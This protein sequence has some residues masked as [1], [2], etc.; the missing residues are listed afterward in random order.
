MAKII[1]SD[2][3]EAYSLCPRKAFLLMAGATSDPGPHDYELFIR[4]QAEANRQVHR[5]RLAKVDEVVP[6]S[7]PADLAV[8]RDVL[9]NVELATGVLQARCDFLTKVDEPSRLGRHSYEPVKVIG[10]CKA[11]R[12]DTLG[13]AYQ[14]L[15]LSEVQGRQPP[16]G[17][18]IRLGGHPCKVKL[19]SKCKD[20][21]RIVDALR[22][23]ADD[24]A[25]DAPPV[26]LNKHCPSCPFRGACLQQAE[27]E[28]NLSLLDRMTP[29]L[30]RKYHDKGIFTVRQL[31]HIYTD[32]LQLRLGF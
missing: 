31:S 25:S 24:P 23:W 28:G 27:K 2:L 26:I 14:C 11:S 32:L 21:R 30:M 4:E 12:T 19:T 13:L 15:V 16:S 1:T 20:V 22:A 3:V 7:G 9:A 6:F 5:V 10:T 17:T 18:L 8:G 29:K